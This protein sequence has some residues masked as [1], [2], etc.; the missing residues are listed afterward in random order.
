MFH[1]QPAPSESTCTF[2]PGVE[3][4]AQIAKIVPKKGREHT[5][6]FAADFCDTKDVDDEASGAEVAAIRIASREILVACP[7]LACICC[8]GGALMLA[9]KTACRIAKDIGTTGA[10]EW[11]IRCPSKL[12]SPVDH[13]MTGVAGECP[14]TQARAIINLPFRALSNKASVHTSLL[15]ASQRSCA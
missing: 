6:S 11:C 4:L 3:D 12:M 15:I 1:L 13:T 10:M 2:S 5:C 7:L 9:V 8:S 14:C